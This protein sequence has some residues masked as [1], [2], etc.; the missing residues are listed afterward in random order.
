MERRERKEG[1]E[2]Y[3]ESFVLNDIFKREFWRNGPFMFLCSLDV[4]LTLSQTHRSRQFRHIV[5]PAVKQEG[6]LFLWLFS[7]VFGCCCGM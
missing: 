2:T 4:D 5:R 7:V 6:H 1:G 3:R